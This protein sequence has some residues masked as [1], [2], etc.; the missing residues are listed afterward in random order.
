MLI[1][2]AGSG[3]AVVN[4]DIKGE[5]V[6][7][8]RGRSP[9]KLARLSSLIAEMREPLIRNVRIDSVCERVMLGGRDLF[10]AGRIS[11]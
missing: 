1:A 5:L 4:E 3:V 9:R 10:A 6:E 8:A 2:S 7:L 11:R